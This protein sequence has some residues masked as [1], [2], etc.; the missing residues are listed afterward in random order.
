MTVVK[1]MTESDHQILLLKRLRLQYPKLM[2]LSVPNGGGRS[3]RE[4]A[5]L[6][7]E[8]VLAGTPDLFIPEL[9]LWIEMK[10]PK[11]PGAAA[12]RVSDAQKHVIGE[13]IRCGYHVRICYGVDEAFAAV[14]EFAKNVK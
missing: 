1:A 5:R 13:L 11:A 3:A 2:V 6:K 14:T 10:R 12:G 7:A 9:R 4:A 8:G